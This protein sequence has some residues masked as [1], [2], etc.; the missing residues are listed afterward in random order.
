MTSDPDDTAPGTDNPIDVAE[1]THHIEILERIVSSFDAEERQRFLVEGL[2]RFGM[3]FNVTLGMADERFP[4]LRDDFLSAVKRWLSL[5]PILGWA[6]EA[7]RRA[8]YATE[9]IDSGQE[10]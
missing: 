7:E 9:V 3:R 4:E 1:V 5:E 2:A 8:H 10:R 6:D